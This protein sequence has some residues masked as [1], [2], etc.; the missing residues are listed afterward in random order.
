[1]GKLTFTSGGTSLQ[2]WPDTMRAGD[3]LHIAFL[4]PLLAGAPPRD[5][6][7][8]TV[9]DHRR[10]RVATVARGALRPAGGVVCIEWDGCDDRGTPLPPGR[11]QLRVLKPASTFLLERTIHIEA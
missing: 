1:M 4:A 8:V 3:R 2:T 10:R 7:E 11:Y 5:E 9:Y 6:F